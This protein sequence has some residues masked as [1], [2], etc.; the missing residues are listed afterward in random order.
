[1]KS[2]D[3]HKPEAF[4]IGA[5]PMSWYGACRERLNA[6]QSAAASDAGLADSGNAPGTLLL[7]VLATCTCT[8]KTRFQSMHTFVE[9]DADSRTQEQ[10]QDTH[11]VYQ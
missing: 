4:W 9:E 11:G 7:N 8:M 10:G 5:K 2:P 1:M 6:C 3:R